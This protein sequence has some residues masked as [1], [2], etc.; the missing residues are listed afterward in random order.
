M[1]TLQAR[2]AL[3]G[4]VDSRRDNF[5]EANRNLQHVLQMYLG[6]AKYQALYDSFSH[7]GG[8]CATVIDEAAAVN[9]RLE[10]HPRLERFSSIGERIEEIDFHPSYHTAGR[11][12]YESGVLSIQSQ[13][14]YA[15]QQAA[16]LFLLC[17]CGEMGHACPIVCTAG[18]IRALQ[19]KGSAY[20]KQTFLP[21][22]LVADYD[23]HQ[24]GAQFV[25]ELQGGSDVGAN[26]CQATPTEKPS[27]W[28]IS[29]EKW[30]CSNINADQF[31]V[32]ARPVDA[33]VGTKGL[34]LFLVPRRLPEDGSLNG[35]YVRRLKTKFGTRTLASAEIDLVHAVGYVVGTV[36]EG[37][38]ILMEQV[39]D[40][41]R[42][43][44]AV[45]ST[46][47]VQRAL[48]EAYTFAQSRLAFGET[49]LQY[50]LVR[51]ALAEI[52]TEV[53]AGIA[54]TF[55]LSHLI[56]R[57]DT[58]HATSQER[59]VYRLLVNINKY[60][61]SVAASLAIR[62][63]QE[64][65]G[66]NG[67]IEDF[68]IVPRLYRD[69]VVFESWE[70]SHNVLC[71]QAL[72]DMMKYR[73]HE[74]YAGYLAAQLDR[75][76]QPALLEYQQAGL[77]QLQN[78]QARL[79]RLFASRSDYTQMHI[80]RVIDQMAALVQF[81]CLLMEAEWELARGLDTDKPDVIALFYNRHLD[82]DHDPL[83]DDAYQ[84]R[85]AWICERW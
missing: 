50:P 11:P 27:V 18:L 66:G 41:S 53:Y 62:R 46:G 10:N 25:T 64:L 63:A 82:P 48:I 68:S 61:T 36:E 30:F 77:E 67:A 23:R 22:L 38:K 83:D 60:W 15:V 14:G 16:L 7:F 81:T 28:R 4:W 20:L 59:G 79:S 71:L 17:H 57:I 39:L 52:K 58:G 45:G 26:V 73:L 74:D 21:P 32:T 84:D 35:F 12:A 6:D 1:N 72:K 55:R 43:L 65:L 33:A 9:D 2:Q 75:V 29:G 42:W 78:V 34:G 70:G 54:S 24:H 5:F 44:N 13:P 85:L 40:T 3:R 8:I 31:L 19:Q 69:S 51:E 37:F 80:R 56:D 76:T 47:L 49:I